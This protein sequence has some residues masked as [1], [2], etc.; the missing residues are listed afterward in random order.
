[1]ALSVNEYGTGS[2]AV[3][4]ENGCHANAEATKPPER[5]LSPRRHGLTCSRTTLAGDGARERRRMR[6][7]VGYVRHSKERLCTTR[8]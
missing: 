6:R 8:R 7:L 4:L 3:L 1:V 2:V 5:V